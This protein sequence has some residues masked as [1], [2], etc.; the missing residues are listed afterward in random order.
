MLKKKKVTKNTTNKTKKKV[1][2]NT[3]SKTK[4]KVATNTGSKLRGME[5]KSLVCRECNVI[6]ITVSSDIGAVVCAYC[7]Q[8][9][10]GPPENIK[11]KNPGEKFP[12]GW[13]F[14]QRYVH[15]DGRV[16]CKGVEIGENDSRELTKKT[17]AEKKTIKKKSK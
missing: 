3:T 1:A 14:K 15:T 7:V 16:F 4:K 6:A 9:Q 8:R 13:H 11:P 12:R 2:I 17:V 5:R 10:V